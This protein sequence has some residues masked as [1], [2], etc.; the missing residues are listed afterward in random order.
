MVV[1]HGADILPG[2]ALHAVLNIGGTQA[3][4]APY[5]FDSQQLVNVMATLP[6]TICLATHCHTMCSPKVMWAGLPHRLLQHRWRNNCVDA[7]NG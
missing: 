3:W 2:P 4:Y 7:N 6:T 5:A 1:A